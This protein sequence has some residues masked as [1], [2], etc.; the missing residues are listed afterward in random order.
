M[1]ACA[2]M[3]P[4]GNDPVCPCRMRAMGLV[5]HDIWTPEKVAEL[6]EALRCMKLKELPLSGGIPAGQ[7][8]TLSVAYSN[9]APGSEGDNGPCPCGNE[10][11]QYDNN[12]G[13]AFCVGECPE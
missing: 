8:F 6:D 9:G 5:P 4:Q 2:C 1:T 11:I 10:V 3:G 7:I 12:T 13:G